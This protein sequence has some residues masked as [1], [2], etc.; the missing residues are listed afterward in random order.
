MG[1]A[2]KTGIVAVDRQSAR[3]HKERQ[4]KLQQEYDLEKLKLEQQQKQKE[5]E[6]QKQQHKQELAKIAIDAK[7]KDREN[8]EK[9]RNDAIQRIQDTI[10]DLSSQIEKH[11]HELTQVKKDRKLIEENL[12]IQDEVIKNFDQIGKL[13]NLKKEMDDA[14]R[15]YKRNDDDIVAAIAKTGQDEDNVGRFLRLTHALIGQTTD[16]QANAN[17]LQAEINTFL[18]MIQREC[19]DKLTIEHYFTENNL[20]RFVPI[21]ENRGIKLCQNLS[22]NDEEMFKEDILSYVE[23]E[24]NKEVDEWKKRHPNQQ[25]PFEVFLENYRLQKFK[26]GLIN[27]GLESLDDITDELDQE[28]INEVISEAKITGL[29]KMKFKKAI[30]EYQSGKYQPPKPKLVVAEIKADDADDEK[31]DE[32]PLEIT[33][34]EI[35]DLR[36]VSLQF[37]E[38][39]LF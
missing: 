36:Q 27:A 39:Y 35:A 24:I 38:Y 20:E 10:K 28:M 4:T 37:C 5:I 2:V 14:G 30:K 9:Q 1:N 25:D 7:I 19:Q 29:H 23:A 33:Q 8:K 26:K 34:Q 31:K 13:K 22:R 6:A 18:T 12:Q 15:E 32:K 16:T 21:L 11:Q 17:K 3:K